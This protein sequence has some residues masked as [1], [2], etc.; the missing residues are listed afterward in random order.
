MVCVR[1]DVCVCVCA[2]CA[3]AAPV[4]LDSQCIA[5]G[6]MKELVNFDFGGPLHSMIIPGDMHYLEEDMLRTFHSVGS[7]GREATGG[8]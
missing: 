7:W 6:P 3:R 4:G 5:S 8:S 2:A 1:G